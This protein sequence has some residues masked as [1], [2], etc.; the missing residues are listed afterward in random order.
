[1]IPRL[2]RIAYGGDYN[3]EQW[4]REVWEED[5][6]LM[7]DAGVNLVSV[8]IFSWALLEPK[9][10][11]FEMGWLD[12]VLDLL[13]R[14]GISID[15]ATATASP[16]PWLSHR[17]PETLPM[18]Y[19]GRRLWPG[20]RQ[21]WCPSSP[22]FREKALALVEQ[23][24]G[25]YG[26]HPGLVLWHVSNELGCH[27]AHCY[28]DVS[29]AA[30]RR[31]LRERYGDLGTLNEAWGTAFWSQRY[32]DW[33]EVLPPRI[34]PTFP[35]PTQQLDFRRFS[36]DELLAYYEAEREVLRRHTP[37]IPVTTNFM[38]A[39][40]KEM[41]YHAWAPAMDVVSNDHYLRGEDPDNHIELAFG[42]DVT[43]GLAGG[44]SWLLMEHSTS[45][46]NWQPRNLAKLPGQMLRNSLQHVARGADG[47]C[48]F[49][50]RASRA[51]AEKFHSGLVPHAGPDSKIWR[52][53]VELGRA[54]DAIGEVRGTTVAADVA[55]LFD[56]QSWW[57][58]ELDS[59]PSVDVSYLDQAHR[60]YRVLWEAGVP[61]DVVH[62]D[63]ELDRYRMVVV[64]TLY[65]VTDGAADRL[66]RYVRGGGTVLVT[67]FS[68]IV[69]ERDHIRLGGYPGAF[70][71]VLGVRTEEFF[72]LRRGQTVGLDDGTS[73]DVWT[74][75]LH[76]DGAEAVVRYEDGPLPGV[77]AVTRHAFGDGAAWYV[78]TRLAP[79][80]VRRLVDRLTGDSGTA[81][82]HASPPGVE[83]VRRV[84]A[85][86]SYLFA[87]NHT[88]DEAIVPVAGTDLL[89]GTAHADGVRIPAGGVAVIR[90]Q[91]LAG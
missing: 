50:W 39:G 5:V 47:V 1:M 23:M 35:N 21:A 70:R 17:Y 34:A 15:L 86:R 7:R 43:R 13:H 36:S 48:F 18:T 37:D 32:G 77:P 25:R 85:D 3:P 12:D 71:D 88:D 26:G 31:W 19:D 53:V 87:L 54:L 79:A 58:C 81:A 46:V 45:A 68:G 90:E 22:V 56:Y 82:G 51:G 69:D 24:A 73:A 44:A 49:Q 4:P 75:L 27:N 41:D 33:E 42:A 64:P 57:A 83:V 61:V 63:T 76:L 60:Y 62:P 66:R 55:L 84:G 80:G 28:C 59:H 74:E 16:P 10:G 30:F 6:A 20:G 52:E 2:P 9:E 29:A 11:S 89:T 72:P 38:V 78:A 91:Q 67:Y 65:L 40:F 14:N 8:G